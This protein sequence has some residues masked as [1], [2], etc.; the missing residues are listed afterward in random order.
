M[1][2]LRYIIH[3]LMKTIVIEIRAF[4][5]NCLGRVVSQILDIILCMEMIKAESTFVN[6]HKYLKSIGKSRKNI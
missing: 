4:V 6:P 1:E 3:F 2:K 5:R